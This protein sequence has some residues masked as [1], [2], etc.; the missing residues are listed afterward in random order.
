LDAIRE[1]RR[2]EKRKGFP[3]EFITIIICGSI[4]VRITTLSITAYVA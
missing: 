1:L 4:T 2:R 3:Y